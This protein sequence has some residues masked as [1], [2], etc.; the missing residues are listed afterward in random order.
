MEK[1]EKI[2]QF[3]GDIEKA[4]E[5]LQPVLKKLKTHVEGSNGIRQAIEE[6]QKRLIDLETRLNQSIGAIEGIISIAEDL[7]E[8]EE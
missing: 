4:P 7:I 5:N 6:T 1:R 3:L 8:D 2:E